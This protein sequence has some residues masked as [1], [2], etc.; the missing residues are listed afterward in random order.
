MC[1]CDYEE[2]HCDSCLRTCREA[3]CSNGR[4]W[5]DEKGVIFPEK[6][7]VVETKTKK[8]KTKPAVF[9]A[10]KLCWGYKLGHCT[11]KILGVFA[12]FK[13]AMKSCYEDWKDSDFDDDD[14]D[15]DD[16]DENNLRKSINFYVP[17]NK[18]ELGK[19]FNSCTVWRYKLNEFAEWCPTDE[20]KYQV[21]R[22]NLR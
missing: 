4:T 12:N 9:V 21:T 11:T 16:E 17:K 2:K 18:K 3:I 19:I 6:L 7:V 10:N 8:I 20:E 14:D 1:E 15:D 13:S 22:E 5:D